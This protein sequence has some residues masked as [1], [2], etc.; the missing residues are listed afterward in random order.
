[1]AMPS[2]SPLRSTS[3]CAP[4][5]RSASGRTAHWPP[6]T[7]PGNCVGWDGSSPPASSAP[8]PPVASSCLL[9]PFLIDGVPGE[10]VFGLLGWKRKPAAGRPRLVHRQHSAVQKNLVDLRLLQ[11]IGGIQI[12][13]DKLQ[14]AP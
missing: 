4:L 8:S 2:R 6:S 9:R 3:P 7:L 13:E 12:Q 1:M 5:P 10:P 11:R 14:I